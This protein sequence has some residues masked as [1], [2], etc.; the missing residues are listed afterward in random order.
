MDDLICIFRCLTT[1]SNIQR[2]NN[3]ITSN[4]DPLIPPGPTK[5]TNIPTTGIMSKPSGSQRR[6][7]SMAPEPNN[8]TTMTNLCRWEVSNGKRALTSITLVMSI[9]RNIFCLFIV[10]QLIL[11]DRVL[12]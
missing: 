10:T 6:I 2:P 1:I 5:G 4:M 11:N 7:T 9:A 3:E 8:N 12:M